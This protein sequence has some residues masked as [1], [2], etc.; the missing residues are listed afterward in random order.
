MF[1]PI[2]SVI[3]YSFT[4]AKLQY[5]DYKFVGFDQYISM[6]TKD[7]I[8]PI[9]LRNTIMA[10]VYIV[11]SVFVLSLVLAYGLNVMKRSRKFFTFIYF[12]PTVVPMVA[13][14]LVW[15]WL[16]NPQYGLFNALLRMAGLPIQ[17]F[18]QS[19]SQ[20]L[21]SISVVQIWYMFGYYAVILLAAMRG[22]SPSLFE[23]ADIDGAGAFVKFFRITLPMIKPNLVFVGIMSTISAFMLFTPVDVLTMGRGTPGTSTMVLI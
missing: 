21:A 18:I 15:A 5:D 9:A 12:L 13:V 4:N 14:C 16:Y 6:F 11:P 10:V 7:P 22:I 3:F 19:G 8:I 23:A 2:A 17:Q 1:L 20:A